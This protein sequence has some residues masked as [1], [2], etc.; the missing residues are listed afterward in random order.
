MQA[1]QE[2]RAKFGPLWWLYYDANYAPALRILNDFIAP[3]V[4]KSLSEKVDEAKNFAQT[5][6]EF[7]DDPK[8]IRDNLVNIL[9]A[10]RDTTAATLSFLFQ[11]LAHDPQVYQRLREEVLQHVGADG[12][13]TYANLKEMKYLQNCLNET[14]RLYPIVPVNGRYALV[15]TTLPLGGGSDGKDVSLFS[16][17]H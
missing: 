13:L 15:D 9:L 14:L 10:G 17:P 4:Q 3:F 7:T 5:L 11:E 6:A 1:I 16:I 12:E 2:V 8:V